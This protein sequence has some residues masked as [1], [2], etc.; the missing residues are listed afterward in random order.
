MLELL[1]LLVL[2]EESVLM[3]LEELL[4]PF[5]LLVEDKVPLVVVLALV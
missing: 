5:V 3:T 1:V 4:V 2:D